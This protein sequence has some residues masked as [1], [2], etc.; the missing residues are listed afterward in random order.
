LPA[1]GDL[2]DEEKDHKGLIGEKTCK[3]EQRAG[4]SRYKPEPYQTGMV[5]KKGG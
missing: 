5:G 3:M 1:G 2:Y 4:R